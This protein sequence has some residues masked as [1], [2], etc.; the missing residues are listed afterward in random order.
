MKNYQS[1][2]LLET[3]LNRLE[4]NKKENSNICRKI[5]V[6]IE[7]KKKEASQQERP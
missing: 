1:I 6:E 2:A 5:R 4:Q 7:R 3:R